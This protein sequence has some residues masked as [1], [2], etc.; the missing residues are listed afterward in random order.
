[1]ERR[2]EQLVRGNA[3]RLHD[4]QKRARSQEYVEHLSSLITIL[5]QSDPECQTRVSQETRQGS[6]LHTRDLVSEH[7]SCCLLLVLLQVIPQEGSQDSN[8][9]LTAWSPCTYNDG[10]FAC[11][12]INCN[13]GICIQF[14]CTVCISHYFLS[15]EILIQFPVFFSP[16]YYRQCNLLTCLTFLK[17]ISNVFHHICNMPCLLTPSSYRPAEYQ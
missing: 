14:P 16:T 5:K 2:K 3:Q 1:M 6:G 15:K 4:I 10:K 17:L 7:L 12:A 9:P 11:I 13:I 8:P